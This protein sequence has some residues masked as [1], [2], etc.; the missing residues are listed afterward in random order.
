MRMPWP[1]SGALCG[2]SLTL[3]R[4]ARD[5][6]SGVALDALSKQIAGDIGIAEPHCEGAIRSR[7]MP[8][9]EGPVRFP[10]LTA[11]CG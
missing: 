11:E 6:D 10:E 8:K 2:I 5:H 4:G 7:L 1:S 3:S 9:N